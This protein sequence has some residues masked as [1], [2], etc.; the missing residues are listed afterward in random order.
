MIKSVY[1]ESFGGIK[2]L[3]IE[4]DKGL[5]VIY[6]DNET[7]KT[8][9]CA[10]IR[11]MLYGMDN[12]RK[13]DI[14]NVPRKRYMPLDGGKMSGSMDICDY[15]ISGTFGSTGKNDLIDV[16]DLSTGEKISGFIGEKIFGIGEKTFSNMLYMESYNS[17]IS[18]D[19]EIMTRLSNISGSADE[20]ISYE[21]AIDGI[22]KE[23][24]RV[25]GR[26]GLTGLEEELSELKRKYA[27]SLNEYKKYSDNKEQI[28]KIE[29]ETAELK[30][31]YNYLQNMLL[32]IECNEKFKRYEVLQNECDVLKAETEQMTENRN[33]SNLHSPEYVY[34]L[35]RKSD[36]MKK[37]GV[38]FLTAIILMLI[39]ISGILGIKLVPLY[40]LFS[41]LPVGAVFIGI[42]KY[43]KNKFMSVKKELD[44]IYRKYN[45]SS[46]EEYAVFF[47]KV[48]SY[49]NSKCGSLAQM[50]DVKQAE[51][52]VLKEELADKAK[53]PIDRNKSDVR[54]ELEQIGQKIAENEKREIMLASRAETLPNLP[55][56]VYRDLEIKEQLHEKL[57]SDLECLKRT[58]EELNNAFAK[59]Q[60]SFASTLNEKTQRI[61]SYVTDGKYSETAVNSEFGMTVMQKNKIVDAAYLSG[62]TLDLTYLS[63]KLALADII[64]NG[65]D[66]FFLFDDAFLQYDDKRAFKA[67]DYLKNCGKQVIYFTCQDR[68]SKYM[69]GRM[70]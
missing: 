19:E 22:D 4:F 16:I 24:R 42:G 68:F 14:R 50:L 37:Y 32:Q 39:S 66:Y 63:L 57:K 1:I 29:N 27:D 15:R 44:N 49:S 17:I 3:K 41:L 59:M 9:L 21:R 40:G 31:K 25:S 26:K 18:S 35:C 69:S 48:S 52:N 70:R 45:V 58:K 10:F 47:D 11:A 46:A 34:D 33:N 43:K 2:D 13:N 8:T 23:I 51:L 55:E 12:S 7:G 5:N 28:E 38:Y 61:L 54:T 30:R 64:L 6:G 65:K 60:K 62:G 36:K 56:E 67:M 20:D 53:Q